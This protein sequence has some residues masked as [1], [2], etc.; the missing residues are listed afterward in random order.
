MQWRELFIYSF[1]A[2]KG[3]PGI[4]KFCKPGPNHDCGLCFN[5]YTIPST[6]QDANR[7]VGRLQQFCCVPSVSSVILPDSPEK[8][9]WFQTPI[10]SSRTCTTQSLCIHTL[11]Q[12]NLHFYLKL[13]LTNR[14][15]FKGLAQ[16]PS[17]GSLVAQGF[18]PQPSD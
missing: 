3:L 2:T 4:L 15:M 17:S 14:L 12:S 6:L 8:M 18:N 5:I 13:L 9:V 16:C 7:D 1:Q 11:T 10:T